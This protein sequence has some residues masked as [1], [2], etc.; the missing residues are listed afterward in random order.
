MVV[1][2]LGYFALAIVAIY[3]FGAAMHHTLLQNIEE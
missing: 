3:E 1:I 2:L